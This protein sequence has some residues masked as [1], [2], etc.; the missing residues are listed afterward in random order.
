MISGP[1]EATITPTNHDLG[2]FEVRRA[3]PS[4]KRRMVGKLG[5]GIPGPARGP[6][7]AG[8]GSSARETRPTGPEEAPAGLPPVPAV[9]VPRAD[10][11]PSA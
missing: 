8:P 6:S 7:S 2:D 9:P 11:P 10:R 3:L 1:I 5:G 4:K